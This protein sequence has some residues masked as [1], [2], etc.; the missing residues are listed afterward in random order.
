MK[1]TGK[2]NGFIEGNTKRETIRFGDVATIE[3]VIVE[4]PRCYKSY[5]D[6]HRMAKGDSVEILKDTITVSGDHLRLAKALASALPAYSDLAER[7]NF[8][9]EGEGTFGRLYEASKFVAEGVRDYRGKAR[10][11]TA[12]EF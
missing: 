3:R 9:H 2:A 8:N 7:M 1:I 12:L 5:Y 6:C 11:S 10:K 4:A